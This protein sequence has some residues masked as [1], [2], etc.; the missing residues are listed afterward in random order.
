MNT[1]AMKDDAVGQSRSTV[2]L[3][4]HSCFKCDDIG[5]ALYP[6]EGETTWY[7]GHMDGQAHISCDDC[8]DELFDPLPL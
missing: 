4:T 6:H 8:K 2:G 1:E 7:I 3:G 5:G